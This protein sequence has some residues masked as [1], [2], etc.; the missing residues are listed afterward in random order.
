MTWEEK[1][2]YYDDSRL[3]DPCPTCGGRGY[4]V[5]GIGPYGEEERLTCEGCGGEG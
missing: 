3:D 2:D 1:M 5:G 4:E